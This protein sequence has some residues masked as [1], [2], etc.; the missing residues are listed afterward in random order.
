MPQKPSRYPEVLSQEHPS[1][2]MLCFKHAEF[3]INNSIFYFFS[4]TQLKP[5][6][7]KHLSED[8]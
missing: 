4:V 8:I 6:I 5:Q 3:Q 1:P 2:E 7:R